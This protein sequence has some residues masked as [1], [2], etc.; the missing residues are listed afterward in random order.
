MPRM[1][2]N[3]DMERSSF[4]EALK[5]FNVTEKELEEGFWQAYAD[6]YTPQ[7]GIEFRHIFKHIKENRESKVDM[8]H[9]I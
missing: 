9:Y 8:R 7:T 6:H 5:R 4:I 2:L 3:D 1:N